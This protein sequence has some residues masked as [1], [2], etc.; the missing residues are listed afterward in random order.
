VC[1][2]IAFGAYAAKFHRPL[3]SGTAIF[4]LALAALLQPSDARYI[5]AD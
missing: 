3:A 1:S 4:V 2:Y 5:G